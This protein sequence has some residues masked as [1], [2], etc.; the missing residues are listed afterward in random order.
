M[1]SDRFCSGVG[2]RR[3]MG[4]KKLGLKKPWGGTGLKCCC[5]EMIELAEVVA[6][7]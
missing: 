2:D 3:V 7:V 4:W 5:I 1:H 6:F